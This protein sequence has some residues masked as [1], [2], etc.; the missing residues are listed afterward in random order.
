VTEDGSAEE[1]A[2]FAPASFRLLPL[3]VTLVPVCACCSLVC[4]SMMKLER[5]GSGLDAVKEDETGGTDWRPAEG[6]EKDDGP[7][8]KDARSSSSDADAD[9]DVVDR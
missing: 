5:E 9:S 1:C 3:L 8:S 2:E 6:G 4:D 7:T